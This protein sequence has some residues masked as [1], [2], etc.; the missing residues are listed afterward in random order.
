MVEEV[1]NMVG[2]KNRQAVVRG[3]R[4]WWKIVVEAKGTT[5]CSTRGGG[6]GGE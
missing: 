5:D 6:G 4:E 2:I 1:L 3:R